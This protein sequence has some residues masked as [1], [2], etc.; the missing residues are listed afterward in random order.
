[1]IV[2]GRGV[3]PA[4][5][6]VEDG[7]E[8]KYPL[9]IDVDGEG[10]A[11]RPK[12]YHYDSSPPVEFVNPYGDWPLRYGEHVFGIED[13]LART[14]ELVALHKAAG[15][16]EPEYGVEDARQDQE[17]SIAVNEAA[18]T[19]EPVH[20]PLGPQ[21][22]WEQAQHEDFYARWERDPLTDA[23][24]LVSQSFGARGAG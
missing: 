15:G 22:P 10:K 24:E 11:A 13:D 9:V 5:Y 20:L 23:G 16:G 3:P 7:A 17:M 8:M 14:R 6:R 21:T 2:G 4:L 1:M 18:R 19:G 12:R